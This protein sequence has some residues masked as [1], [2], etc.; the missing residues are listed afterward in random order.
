MKHRM[1]DGRPA[2]SAGGRDSLALDAL[3]QHTDAHP[4]V[5]RAIDAGLVELI[6]A[7]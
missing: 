7:L 2:P 3:H 6:H 5:L 4:E 1:Q